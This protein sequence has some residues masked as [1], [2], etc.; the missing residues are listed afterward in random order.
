MTYFAS[1]Q[2]DIAQNLLLTDVD[3]I[4]LTSDISI[5]DPLELSKNVKIDL[6]GYTLTIP[7]HDGVSIVSGD[8]LIENGTIVT[9]SSDPIS[10]LNYETILTLGDNLKINS[11]QCAIH[12]K[13]RG[14]VIVDGADM[15][16]TGDY[17]AIFV[18][19]FGSAKDN[20]KLVVKSGNIVSKDHVA[21]SATKGGS[22]EVI[23]GYI[24]T[25][26]NPENRD[27]AHS[28][29]HV[30]GGR[31]SLTIEG[32][33]VY[34]EHTSSV[35]VADG[36]KFSITNGTATSDS[37]NYPSINL[38]DDGTSLEMYGGQIK[39]LGCDGI[40]CENIST[41]HALSVVIHDGLIEVPSNK[42][43]VT[44]DIRSQEPLVKIFGGLF[45]G[46]MNPSHIPEGYA[47]EILDNGYTK[48]SLRPD[49]EDDGSEHLDPG[50]ESDTESSSESEYDHKD[51][52]DESE[53]SGDDEDDDLK[54]TGKSIKLSSLTPVY[55]STSTRYHIYDLVGSAT[56]LKIE[57]NSVTNEKY[58]KIQFIRPGHGGRSVGFILASSIN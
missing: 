28:A 21:V 18:E 38:Y 40:F 42:K 11:S 52:E 51:S 34:S 15:M 30:S 24:E 53:D 9:S 58:Y 4:E 49:G 26:C 37:K 23:G 35:S 31:S 55:G 10:V 12:I 3:C 8:V 56:I 45:H 43:L 22:I 50:S 19:G 16:S 39:S 47:A 36:A 1:K 13:R 5:E 57:E 20:S 7:I 6:N 25:Q 27:N 48:V 46:K 44:Y 41:Y 2:S 29:I 54:L 32:G 33:D 17:A 14:K